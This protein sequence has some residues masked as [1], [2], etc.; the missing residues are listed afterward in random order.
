MLVPD[1]HQ[2]QSSFGAVDCDLPDDFVENLTVELLPD[3][4]DSGPF[5]LPFAEHEVKF[6]SELK[7]VLARGGL[8]GNV[9]D[10]ELVVMVGPVF[11]RQDGVNDVWIRVT[12]P[13]TLGGEPLDSLLCFY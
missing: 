9:L 11:G 3:G 8:M 10:M 12:L 2:Q 13:Y 4:T 1:P 7:D 5:G 6:V